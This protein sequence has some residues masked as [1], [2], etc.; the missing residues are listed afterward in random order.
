MRLLALGTGLLFVLSVVF[1]AHAADL[2][3][4]SKEAKAAR[5]SLIAAGKPFV[6]KLI[7]AEGS[8]K[9]VT[10]EVTQQVSTPNPDGARQ[11]STIQRQ[12]AEQQ[13]NTNL[14]ERQRRLGEL[15][16]DLEKAKRN[17][18]RTKDER[19]RLELLTADELKVRTLVPPLD[20]DDK[21]KPK[22]LTPKEL[23]ELK[24]PDPKLPGYTADFDSLKPGQMVEVHVSKPKP[25]AKP[26]NK[27]KDLDEVVE[28]DKPQV[29]MI[30]IVKEAMQ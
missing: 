5:D 4:E 16:V 23:K 3:K 30:V 28:S 26:K 8:Q 21:G 13:R 24:G 14:A 19:H 6:A 9:Y 18:V 11:V 7:Q 29:T 25:A 2:K 27:D 1:T 17:L 15:A 12:I 20:Y 22:K 10:V